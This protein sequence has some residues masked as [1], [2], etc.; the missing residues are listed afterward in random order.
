[1]AVNKPVGDN[2]RKGAVKKR[3]QLKTTLGGATAWTKRNKKGGEFTAV[4]KPAKKPYGS[5]GSKS[6][7]G[8]SQITLAGPPIFM[9]A[10]R[11]IISVI[12]MATPGWSKMA[13][14][15]FCG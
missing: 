14:P 2:A 7:A 4:K 5:P 1:M 9:N 6:S 10:V 8:G 13:V 11:R 15:A 3:T 12:Q